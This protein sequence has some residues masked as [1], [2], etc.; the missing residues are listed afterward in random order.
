MPNPQTVQEMHDVPAGGRSERVTTRRRKARQ[1]LKR[2]FGVVFL[3]VMGVLAFEWILP[4]GWRLAKEMHDTFTW[5]F[6]GFSTVTVTSVLLWVLLEPISLRRAHLA[7]MWWYPPT[8]VALVLAFLLVVILEIFAPSLRH[9]GTTPRWLRLEE[10]IAISVSIGGA[11]LL[12]HMARGRR[13]RQPQRGTDPPPVVTTPSPQRWTW[14]D[15]RD[16]LSRGERP[17]EDV[18]SD[19]LGRGS[20]S[21]RVA[22]QLTEGRSVA[23]L[24][25]LGS[26]K[27][28]VLNLVRTRLRESAS[29]T[30]LVDFD[31]WAVPRAEEVPR[32]AL[33]RIVEALDNYVDTIALR[34]VPATYQRL[35]AAAPVSNLSRALG[36]DTESD[37]TETL[38]R[39]D[40]ILGALDARLVLIVE[41]AE[42]TG[43]TFDTRHL[44]RLLWALREVPSTCFVLA[45]DPSHSPRI[46]FAKLCDTVELLRPLD[47]KD[48]AIVLLVAVGHWASE[49]SDIDPQPERRGK[50]Q[51]SYATEG[52]LLEYVYRTNENRPLRHMARILQTPRNLKRFVQRVD[53]A[54]KHLH[55]E[56]DLEDL[57]IVTALREAATPVYE[58]LISHID[59]ARCEPGANLFGPTSVESEWTQCLEPLNTRE[60][61][62]HLVELLGITQLSDKQTPIPPDESPQG[63]HLVDP[64]DYFR[65]ISAEQLDLDELRDQTVLG[66]IR[67]WQRSG[68][69][70]LTDRLASSDAD[71]DRYA[72]VW[73]HFSGLHGPKEL[74][75]L[76]SRVVHTLLEVDGSSPTLRHPAV[77]AMWR[78]F[79]RREKD[80]NNKHLILDLIQSSV[81]NHVAFA[82]NFFHY[83]TSLDARIVTS[84]ERDEIRCALVESI[85]QTLHTSA[86]FVPHLGDRDAVTVYA[87]ITKTGNGDGGSPFELWSDH[88]APILA[89]GAKRY[90]AQFLPELANLL[91]TDNSR[92]PSP[93]RY[94]PIFRHEYEIDR[95]RAQALLGQ[96]LD[97]VLVELSNYGDDDPYAQRAKQAA[98]AWLQ[99]RRDKAE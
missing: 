89:D 1:A 93:D 70:Q 78:V 66:D 67:E 72:A 15:I 16:W 37:S 2:W 81:P 29:T 45:L 12:R 59:A 68:S 74:A 75:Q 51:L 33:A 13:I 77:L 92:I 40:E 63:V 96:F 64:T 18:A 35:V 84:E 23:L 82:V 79:Q 21:T 3:A 57:L 52:G 50:L 34:D 86:D 76:A 36:L 41:D 47:D 6:L 9:P 11:V 97:D 42:R 25:P 27:S 26:G 87:L 39:L 98:T 62:K 38:Q 8:W 31:V 5:W 7:N 53:S 99:E 20:L 80:G 85:Q 46:D 14:N 30:I 49:Y 69:R 71:G 10:L 95:G 32:L 73:E 61:A 55:G 90:P 54:W 94:P 44:Q 58:F 4:P 65:R 22:V 91:A 24:G 88:L 28:S 83:W 43:K 19:L 60:S 48:V 17:I 56:V